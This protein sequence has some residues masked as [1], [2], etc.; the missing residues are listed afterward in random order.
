M[1]K[2]S[3]EPP[4]E[5]GLI[6]ETKPP[7]QTLFAWLRG[8][9]FAGIVIAAPIGISIGG[10]AWLIS[11]IDAQVK[12]LLPPILKPETY[13]NIAIPGFGVLVAIVGLTLLGAVATN[14]IGRAVL[15][16]SDRVLSRIPV[17][18][19]IYNAFKQLFDL[20]GS[21]ENANF[22][23]VV[24]VEYPKRGTWCVG[25]LTAA[26]KGEIR[27]NLSSDYMG[28]FVPTTPNPT[29]GFLMYIQNE[30]IIRLKMSIEEGAKMIISGGLVVPDELPMEEEDRARLTAPREA[31]EAGKAS[32][33]D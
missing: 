22:K 9:F 19:N 8:R 31:P 13:T 24:L 15:R 21:N 27:T 3:K 28:V 6:G 14:L 4:H 32:A 12:P 5:G 26:A 17:V 23:E 10:V 1:S 16:L 25:F 20:L 2:R 33:Q 29:S 11:Y 18:S 7:R 30:E